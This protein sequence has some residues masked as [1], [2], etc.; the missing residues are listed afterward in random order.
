[1]KCSKVLNGMEAYLGGNLSPGHRKNFEDHLAQCEKC[2]AELERRKSEDSLY[3][4]ALTPHRLQGTLRN[5]V[6]SRLRSRP[7]QVHKERQVARKKVLWLAPVAAAA[8]FIV[9][10]W[11]SG[12]FMLEVPDEHRVRASGPMVSINWAVDLDPHLYFSPRG[13]PGRGPGSAQEGAQID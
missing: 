12:V 6:L 5:I 7:L 3:R 8:Q 10:F 11:L 4:Q 2:R 1:M 13:E 9:A